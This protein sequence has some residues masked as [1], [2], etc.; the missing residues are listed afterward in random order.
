MVAILLAAAASCPAPTPE[1]ALKRIEDAYRSKDMEAVVACKDFRREAELMMAR[2]DKPFL[3]NDPA[4]VARIAETLESAFREELRGR[5]FPELKGV[6]CRVL[7]KI[8]GSSSDIVIATEQC[9]HPDGGKSVQ[10]IQLAK[11]GNDWRVLVPVQD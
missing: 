9:V 7:E 2:L 6:L 8:P 3:K 5:G 11:V 4:I 1:V 10:R